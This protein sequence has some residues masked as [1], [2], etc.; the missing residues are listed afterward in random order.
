M[1]PA[2]PRSEK[3]RP[4]VFWVLALIVVPL[5]GLLAR[6]R[7]VDGHKLPRHGAFIVSPNH[8]SEIDPVVVGLALWKLGRLPRFLAKESLFRVPV[9]GWFLRKSGQV[10]VAR[11]G[12]GRG[13][14]P[15]DAAQ[16]IVEDGRVVV[17]Y[18]EGSLTRDPEMWP[19]RGKTGAAR[20]ALEHGI[21]VVPI[22]HWGAQ[23]VMARYANR[24]SVFPRKTIAVKVGDPVD[25]SAFT[26]R[27]LDAATLNE[28]TDVIMA[29]ITAL[30]A[31]LRGEK[32]P[33][34]RWDP[35]QHNQKETGRFDG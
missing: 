1:T 28:A 23:Q 25:L 33:E 7:I 14:A 35:S 10:P 19:M 30:L 5:G 16:R 12:S 11:G 34:T 26:G 29:A 13:S 27:S 20:M 21:P 24:I 18:P 9:L 6:F 8:Y 17:I 2:R 15:L 4:S 31:D 3:S 32:A 22:A